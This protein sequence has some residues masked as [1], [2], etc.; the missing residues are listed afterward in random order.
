[1]LGKNGYTVL[2]ICCIIGAV[3]TALA[4]SGDADDLLAVG[5]VGLAGT[6]AGR[7]N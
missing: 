6:I 5:L 3:V 2:A 7:G 1:M 4:G